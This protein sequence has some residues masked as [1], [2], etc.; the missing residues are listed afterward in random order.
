[1]D[2]AKEVRTLTDRRGVEVVVDSVGDETWEQSLRC[3]ARLGRLVTCGSTTGP[4]V[5]T[6]L[7]KLFWYQWTIMGS[8]MGN[9]TDF[10]AVTR[11]AHAGRL[12]P[13]IDRSF[14]LAEAPT[15]FRRLA[16]G[17]QLGKVI[18]QVDLPGSAVAAERGEQG[19]R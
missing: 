1:V 11:L 12:W 3:L 10:E 17:A 14:P 7:R 13:E 5:S 16:D 18:V 6:D 4:M 9:D 2:V 15:A 19:R 8:T